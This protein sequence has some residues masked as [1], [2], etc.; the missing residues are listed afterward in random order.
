MKSVVSYRCPIL[1]CTLLMACSNAPQKNIASRPIEQNQIPA[2]TGVKVIAYYMGDVSD[3]SRY[4]FNQL[5]HIIYS[6]LHLQGNQL[7]FDSTRDQ[8]AMRKPRDL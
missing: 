3:L 5:T 8:E 4:N 1:L 7:T 2:D 6:F